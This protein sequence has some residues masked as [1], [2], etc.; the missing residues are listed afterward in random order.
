MKW[1]CANCGHTNE[2]ETAVTQYCSRCNV[3]Q[4]VRH[5]SVER[6]HYEKNDKA[7]ADERNKCIAVLDGIIRPMQDEIDMA[8]KKHA[9]THGLVDL[10]ILS[11]KYH[12]YG[13]KLAALNTAKKEME[14]GQ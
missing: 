2:V 1:F 11:D 8:T 12:R 13:D 4:G 3:E 9:K 14:C 6:V 5:V 10:A 7:R